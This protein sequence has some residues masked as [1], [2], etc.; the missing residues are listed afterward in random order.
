MSVKTKQL[1]LATIND[2][3]ADF[4]YYDRKEDEELPIG[5][6]NEAVRADVISIGEIVDHFRSEL[7]KGLAE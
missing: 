7:H 3:I 2:L 5:A 1:I 6:I 4:L